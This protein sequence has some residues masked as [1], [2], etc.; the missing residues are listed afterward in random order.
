LY[1]YD[2]IHQAADLVWFKNVK[3]TNDNLPA[4][5]PL[6]DFSRLLDV[7]V[8]AQPLLETA[9]GGVYKLNIKP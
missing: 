7:I 6:P 2:N 1:I 9:D 5:R 4:P 3:P 8:R